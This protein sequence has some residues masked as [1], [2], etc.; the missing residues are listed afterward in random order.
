MKAKLGAALVLMSILTAACDRGGDTA[1]ALYFSETERGGEPFA[2]RMLVTSKFLRI[3]YGVD[4]DDFI[5]FD[6]KRPTIFSV[7]RNDKTVLVIEPLPITLAAPS[8][9]EHSVEQD[10]AQ[11]PAVGG[12]PVARFR[13]K[14]NHTQCYDVFAAKDLLPD[15]VAALREYHETIA[16]Q[17]A[18]AMEVTPKD[19][20]RACDLANYIFAPT[21]HLAQGFPVRQQDIEG[22]TRQ[23]VNYKEGFAVDPMLFR[24][25]AE[26]KHYRAGENRAPL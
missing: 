12:K 14:T 23:L 22:N 9:F 7:N 11:A 18:R 10:S 3:D 15:A 19:M 6:R 1:V 24:L 17:H 2:T 4:T 5:L 13:F 16:G 21:R 25:P 8:P 20:Q 26:F